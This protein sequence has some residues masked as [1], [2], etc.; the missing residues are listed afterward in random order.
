MPA[1]EYGE[2]LTRASRLPQREK[3]NLLAELANQIRDIGRK[4]DQSRTPP[5]HPSTEPPDPRA[6]PAFGLWRDHE[7]WADPVA[8]VRRLREGRS[9]DV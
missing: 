4:A 9:H 6:D 5:K 3:T 1:T 7:E 2:L 8:V